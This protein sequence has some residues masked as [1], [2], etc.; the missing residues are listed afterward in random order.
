MLLIL[1]IVP[2][3]SLFILFTEFMVGKAQAKRLD[4]PLA[5]NTEPWIYILQ[6]Q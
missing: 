1:L 5:S 2:S 4:I 6:Q 3:V